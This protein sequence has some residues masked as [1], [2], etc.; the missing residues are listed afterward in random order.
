M[1]SGKG[2]REVV[3]KAIFS[4]P[5]NR[6]QIWVWQTH[7]FHPLRRNLPDWVSLVLLPC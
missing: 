4:G 1:C 5:G 7:L 2:K 6:T 3:I